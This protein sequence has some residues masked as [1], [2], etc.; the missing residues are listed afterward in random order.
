MS[1]KAEQT[2]VICGHGMV[3]QR[4]LE[5]LVAQPHRPFAR[6]VV[7]NGEASPAYNRIQLSA[8]LAGDA[9]EDSLQLQQPDWYQHNNITLHQG[10]P[11][12]AINREERTVTTASGRTQHYTSL[13]LATGSRSASL[14]LKGEE[15]D[16]VMGFRDLQDTRRLINI[17]QRHRRAVVI[18]G[19]FLGLEAAEGLRSRGM[20]VTVLH[21]S[22]HL[23][24]RQLDP[25]GG[26]LL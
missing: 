12:T 25:A 22:G 21:R 6:I 10:D 17:S 11:V 15:L 4:L 26:A 7:F 19:G 9:N 16:G 20:A 24:N 23:L 14:G 18:G 5:K 1:A 13:V 8:L 3:A 2:L